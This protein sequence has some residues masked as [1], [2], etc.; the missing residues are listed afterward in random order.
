MIIPLLMYAGLPACVNP[1][2]V[3]RAAASA[4]VFVSTSRRVTP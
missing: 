1:F 4:A 2:T 3:F